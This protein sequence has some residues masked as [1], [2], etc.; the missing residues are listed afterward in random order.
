MDRQGIAAICS[1]VVEL[2]TAWIRAGTAV[3]SAGLALS[4]ASH[5]QADEQP[6][7]SPPQFCAQ[8][9]LGW[10][11]AMRNVA[12]AAKPIEQTPRTATCAAGSPR[13]G[14]T[15]SGENCPPSYTRDRASG[16]Q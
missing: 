1:A 13:P 7:S 11:E 6:S 14:E 4:A 15:G 8:M 2:Q 3:L 9:M 10:A 12:L 16:N 5:A